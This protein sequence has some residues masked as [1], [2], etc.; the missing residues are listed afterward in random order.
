MS[1]WWGKNSPCSGKGFRKLL[2]GHDDGD[3]SEGDDD[4]HE[5]DSNEDDDN[6]DKE[7]F[8]FL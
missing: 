2:A 7:D 3:N 6:D 5:D 1:P 8:F 4:D